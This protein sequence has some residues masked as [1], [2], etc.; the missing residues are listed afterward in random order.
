VRRREIF[1]RLV[2]QFGVFAIQPVPIVF[3]PHSQPAVSVPVVRVAS[4][5]PILFFSAVRP[6]VSIRIFVEA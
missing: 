4:A 3:A 2:H 1:E 5:T 6:K